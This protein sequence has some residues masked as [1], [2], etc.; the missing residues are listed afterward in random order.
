MGLAL[1]VTVASRPCPWVVA[2]ERSQ[3]V[4]EGLEELYAGLGLPRPPRVVR[5]ALETRELAEMEYQRVRAA[6]HVTARLMGPEMAPRRVW[7][8]FRPI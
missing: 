6:A 2:Y 5:V 8:E 1:I 4:L 7:M 3:T